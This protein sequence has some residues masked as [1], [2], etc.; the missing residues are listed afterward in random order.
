MQDY[1]II[2]DLHLGLK[3]NLGTTVESRKAFEDYQFQTFA[4]ILEDAKQEN[5]IILGD[6]F[7]EEVVS[8][9]VL[10][11]TFQ[12]LQRWSGQLIL[13]K[14]NHDSCKDI[15]N[16]ASVDFLSQMLPDAML[17]DSPIIHNGFGI[18][19]HMPSQELFDKAVFQ[20]SKQTKVLLTHC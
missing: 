2:S 11:R 10:W 7:D 12:T 6:L 4:K 14:G 13:C 1:L 15:S 18:V 17:V 3:R 16:M 9:D 8:L 5:L 19:P 20:M